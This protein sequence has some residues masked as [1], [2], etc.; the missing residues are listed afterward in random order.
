MRVEE[1]EEI[2]AA[3]A[4]KAVFAKYAG[5]FDTVVIF[6]LTQYAQTAA[7]TLTNFGED[8][9]S[10]TIVA[11]LAG[12]VTGVFMAVSLIIA[13]ARWVTPW[14]RYVMK[15]WVAPGVDSFFTLGLGIT[16][17]AAGR[18]SNA[19]TLDGSVSSQLIS[20]LIVVVITTTA[21]KIVSSRSA[22]TS[23]SIPSQ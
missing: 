5:W 12:M 16:T 4:R 6:F 19:L 15:G 22:D 1:T 21:R 14:V 17:A 2:P 8:A 9:P 7:A 10:N 11:V 13:S 3:T 23:T 18:A 20:M